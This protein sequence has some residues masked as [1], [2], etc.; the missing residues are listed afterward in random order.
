[1]SIDLLLRG[2]TLIDGTGRPPFAA[3]LAIRD[4]R[5][6]DIGTIPV[7]AGTPFLDVRGLYVTPGFID[8]H[9][10]SDFTL[11]VDPR[12]VS[13][14]T[15]GVTL[16]VVGNC[17][18]GCAP[19]ADPVLARSN[20]YGCLAGHDITWRSMGEYLDR[21][22]AG[23][24][25][26]NVATLVPNGNLRLAVAGLVDRPSTPSERRRMHRLLEK[27]LE[28]GALGYSTGLEYG[29]ERACSEDEVVEL[30]RV[31]AQR[32]GLYATHTRNRQGEA[33]ETIAEAL[34]ACE[35]SGVRLQISHISSV[36]R[37]ADTSGWAVEQALEQVDQA[38]KRSLDVG[39]DMHTRL[40]GTTNLSA[41][42][43][44]SVLEG[45]GS[46][47]AGRL[48]DLSVRRNLK[49]YRSILT[50]L[51]GG[52]WSRIVLFDSKLQPELSRRSIAEISRER[53]VE[54]L[55]AICD[56]L[57]GELD[58]LHALMVIAFAYREEDLRCAYEHPGCAIGSDATALAPD[59]PL[60]GVSFHGAY[61]WASWFY[62]HFVRDTGRLSAQ[63]AIRRITSLPASRLGLSDRGTLRPGAWADVAVFDPTVFAERGTTFEPNQ[64]AVGMKHV[65][66]NGVLTLEDGK[67]TGN[68]A[69]AVLRQ[70]QSS[71]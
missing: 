52:D 5:I 14:I 6:T 66:V 20:I 46:E 9:S 19:I 12:A 60:Q 38:R 26:V 59:G 1:M 44:P 50:S 45:T 4:G 30:C 58:D 69:G 10:H 7:P 23:R 11:V 48:R 42:L 53:G 67:L 17:G 13:S 31:T 18:H 41:A 55:D 39:F 29:P 33:K 51:A 8:I 61:T 62:R 24:P 65:L 28:E 47:I 54:P 25:A 34:R 36:A 57:L 32:G 37:L 40:F 71:R 2:G 56:I 63:E 16:E 22:A 68:R 49:N 21:L 27:S 35:A 43:P 15:Q 64:P 70:A 3:D